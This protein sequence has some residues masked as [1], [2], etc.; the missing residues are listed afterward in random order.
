M[1]PGDRA[2]RVPCAGPVVGVRRRNDPVAVWV[3]SLRAAR[4]GVIVEGV[5]TPRNP[6]TGTLHAGAQ[7][8]TGTASEPRIAPRGAAIWPTSLGE[9][10]APA[11]TVF[12]FLV[13]IVRSER[14]RIAVVEGYQWFGMIPFDAFGWF[15]S[16][17]VD[18]LRF[19]PGFTFGCMVAVFVLPCVAVVRLCWKRQFSRAAVVACWSGAANALGML[20][21]E[22]REYWSMH[23]D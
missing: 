12:A 14:R 21:L 2:H 13:W 15:D 1:V 16:D 17:A 4:D 6:P 11:V 5:K 9:W 22:R 23:A 10:W 7:A 3:G 20:V 8:A 19:S 18:A